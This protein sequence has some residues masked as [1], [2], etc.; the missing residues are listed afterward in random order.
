MQFVLTRVSIFLVVASASLHAADNFGVAVR[1]AIRRINPSVVRIQIIGLPDRAGSVV[2]RTTTGVIVSERG[3]IVSSSFGFG[4]QIAALFVEDSRGKRHAAEI[5]AQDHV[6]KLVLLSSDARGIPAPQWSEVPPQVG[7]W[8]IAA[9]RFYPTELPSAALG[10]VSAV[11]RIHGMAIQTDAK[12]S[13]VNYGGP[14]IG[15]DGRAFGVLVPLAPGNESIGVSAGVEWYDSGIGFAIPVSGIQET[16]AILRTGKDRY[17]GLLGI[18]M[19]TDNPLSESLLIAA[20]TADSPAA[21]AGMRPGDTVLAANGNTMS[22]VGIL[23]SV[24]KR[25]VAGD[26]VDFTIKRGEEQIEVSPTLVKSLPVPQPGWLGIVPIG[27]VGQAEEEEEET[28]ADDATGVLSRIIANSPAARAGIPTTT[29]ITKV[30]DIAITSTG[31]LLK[32]CRQI[33]TDSTWTLECVAETAPNEP[34]TFQLTA[35]KLSSH[36]RSNLSENIPVIRDTQLGSS[37]DVA[38]QTSST[39]LNDDT[40]LWMLAPVTKQVEAELGVVI[41]LQDEPPVSDSLQRSWKDVCSRNNLV[42][43]V[44]SRDNGLPVSQPQV[45]ARVMSVAAKSGALDRDRVVLVSESLHA[46][47]VAQ[48]VSNPRIGPLRLAVFVGCRPVID[49]GSTDSIRQKRPSLLFM[50]TDSDAEDAALL[51]TSVA[52]L[53][54]AGA[55]VSIT[56]HGLNNTAAPADTI[57]NWLWTQKIH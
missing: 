21:R 33:E 35:T 29:I 23:E 46:E 8:S 34:R 54:S 31:Q 53:R 17:R 38:W 20:V 32:M 27:T 47:F 19:N 28:K 14:L 1:S 55:D 44:V 39:N 51:S 42:L 3:E 24:L 25:S 11:G 18:Q 12:V 9:G 45:L 56:D 5:V 7:A 4:G 49:S 6:R 13:P 2:S 10:V 26:T 36:T 50:P 40:Y 52:A 43:A 48:A 22:R 16:V 30:N 15:M 57:S 41:L 37:S